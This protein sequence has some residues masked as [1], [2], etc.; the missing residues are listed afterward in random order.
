MYRNQYDVSML[1]FVKV[2]ERALIL[3]CLSCPS[4]NILT[5]PF[6]CLLLGT[7]VEKLAQGVEPGDP[8]PEDYVPGTDTSFAHDH[9][10]TGPGDNSSCSRGTHEYEEISLGH[11]K[12]CLFSVCDPLFRVLPAFHRGNPLTEFIHPPFP[13]PHPS[14]V[15]GKNQGERALNLSNAYEASYLSGA[16]GRPPQ[17]SR[18][19]EDGSSSYDSRTIIPIFVDETR[20][21]MLERSK[22]LNELRKTDPAFGGKANAAVAIQSKALTAPASSATVAAMTGGKASLQSGTH[23]GSSAAPSAGLARGSTGGSGATTSKPM[24]GARTVQN[25]NVPGIVSACNC[26]LACRQ[27]G[28]TRC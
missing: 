17:N 16:E 15:F 7:Q 2:S 28:V 22:R 26:G 12:S 13:D 3:E 5:L 24:Q 25:S 27:Y 1:R 9:V 4:D 10:T 19:G 11:A 6:S 18:S 14:V 20:E 8:V 21:E 23:M